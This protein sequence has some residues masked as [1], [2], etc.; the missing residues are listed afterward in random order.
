M[1]K[2]N[3]PL[4]EQDAHQDKNFTAKNIR[5]RLIGEK[6]VILQSRVWTDASYWELC[7]TYMQLYVPS[8][9]LI[10]TELDKRK[11]VQIIRKSSF[12]NGRRSVSIFAPN[13][14]LN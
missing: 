2:G 10:Q 5:I 11:N 4:A 7:Y 8:T 1:L 9:W 12:Y 3:Y 13:F 6:S 14:H